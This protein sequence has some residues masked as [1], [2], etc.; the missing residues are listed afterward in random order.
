MTLSR[1]RTWL[2]PAWWPTL[3]VLAT[4]LV[5]LWPAI[6]GGQAI[7]WGVPLLQFQPWH[8]FAKTTVLAG[9]L[10]LWNPLVGMGA[11]LLANAQSAL[12][13]PPN[14][15]LLAIPVE[16]GHA[17]LIIFHWVLAGAGM[18]RLARRLGL[19]LLAQSVAA[20]AFSL[21]GYVVARAGFLS[22]NA[23]LG[24]VPWLILVGDRL[25]EPHARWRRTLL[26]LTMA[27]QILAGH[28]Q[29]WW[30]TWLLLAA[31][32][33][34]RHLGDNRPVLAVLRRWFDVAVS[35]ALA[36][37]LA[38]AQVLPTLEYLRASQRASGIDIQ[39][40]L[41]YSFWPWRL[42]GLIAPDL[43]GNPAR[44]LFWGFANY[45]EDAIYI[46]LL[47]LGLS[48]VALIA[49]L[50]RRREAQASLPRFP[51]GLLAI[52]LPVA[53]IL[54]LGNN[55]PLFPLLY[56][57]V[58]TFDLFQ[59][60]TRIMLIFVFALALLAGAGAERWGTPSPGAKRWASRA[61][62][63]TLAILLAAG[64]AALA[65]DT[66]SSFIA[67]TFRVG[68]T[69]LA[70][71]IVWR[72]A[73]M[74]EGLP[75][76]DTPP[77][78]RPTPLGNLAPAAAVLLVAV[79]LAYA[80][81]GL[82]PATG[83]ELYQVPN[84]SSAKLAAAASGH[85]YY[86]PA[87]DEYAVKFQRFFRFDTFN[88]PED[89]TE[90]RALGLPNTG[91]LDGLATAGNFDPLLPARSLALLQAVDALPAEQ[92][93][94]LWRAMDVGALIRAGP[95][96]PRVEALRNEPHR[97]WGVCRATWA[98]GGE[99]S[100][101][102]VLDPG[103]DPAEQVI[104]E[105]GAGEEGSPCTLPPMVTILSGNDPNVVALEANFPQPGFLVLADTFYPGWQARV[106]G[107]TVPLLQANFSF[108]AVRLERGE[109]HVEFFYRPLPLAAGMALSF[110]AWAG[111]AIIAVVKMLPRRN[112]RTS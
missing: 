56:R 8:Q 5:I 28:W 23:A 27:M 21:S 104:L 70:C 48:L 36:L 83:R 97:A 68:I 79:D 13:Y 103:F 66:Q 76:G 9:H 74:R 18:S 111:L 37:A 35:T 41:T 7:F 54:A 46:G 19:G 60:P 112:T 107:E 43:F 47:P 87:Q 6:G 109:H 1:M 105:V 86:V 108:R 40:A 32:V 55:T 72:F 42:A 31:W 33:A 89:W 24:W 29:T 57:W 26:A 16:V 50:R 77:A 106:D 73:R 99:E 44:G 38:A 52:C 81:Y 100:L 101:A 4:S 3:I 2:S 53:L 63:A 12:L 45:W 85:R 10:P 94:T 11:P 75:G 98:R 39:T 69:A 59:A 20:L 96:A 65:L 93:H 88:A 14:W 51:F 84:P 90:V 17:W 30:Y 92:Q 25:S 34:A 82:N 49:W 64:I 110:L 58:P 91:M 15:L 22:L 78:N 61:I 62:A 95:Q 80:G 71:V 67:S 102:F